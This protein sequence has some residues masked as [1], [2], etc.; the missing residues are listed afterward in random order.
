VPAGQKIHEG[1]DRNSLDGGLHVSDP[2]RVSGGCPEQSHGFCH[3]P[4]FGHAPS[5]KRMSG[6][7]ASH[8]GQRS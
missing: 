2:T 1:D 5:F 4:H 8:T 7:S 6:T 3:P